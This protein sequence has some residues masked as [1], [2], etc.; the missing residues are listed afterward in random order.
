MDGEDDE[1]L[2]ELDNEFVPDAAP[3]PPENEGE[4]SEP[5]GSDAEIVALKEPP[6][7]SEILI[8]DPDEM[9]S[10]DILSTADLTSVLTQRATDIEGGAQP[11]VDIT[12][13][14]TPLEV[15]M[16]EIIE[17]RNPM[18]VLLYAGVA[19]DGRRIVEKR[20]VNEMGMK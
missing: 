7:S 12:G 20:K 13:C 14:S 5:E 8:T 1:L 17:K 11:F 10:S 9:L 18:C 16:K 3:E 2:P 6:Q 15:A 4:D 19:P